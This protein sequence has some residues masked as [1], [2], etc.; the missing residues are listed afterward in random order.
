MEKRSTNRVYYALLPVLNS[1]SVLKAEKINVC[2]TLL[3][4]EATYRAK[5]LTWNGNTAKWLAAFERKV[6]RKM[7]W[8]V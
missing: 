3:R 7:F 6:L 4:P 8:G 2:K 5:S 1:Q